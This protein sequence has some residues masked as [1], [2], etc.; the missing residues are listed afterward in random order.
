MK[1]PHCTATENVLARLREAADQ[2]I[3]K[4][5]VRL[6]VPEGNA[7]GVS[8]PEI[9]RIARTIGK[10][11]GLAEALWNTGWREARILA[12]LI[13]PR[14]AATGPLL[15]RW[16]SECDSWAEVD[17]LC[18]NLACRSPHSWQLVEPWCSAQGELQ[19]RAGFVLIACLALHDKATPDKAFEELLV[20]IG[21]GAN[22]QRN[23]VMK[24]VSWAL[25]EIGKRSP[26]LC[27]KALETAGVLACSESTAARWI[28]RDALRDLEKKRFAPKQAGS[29]A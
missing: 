15:S 7:L 23:L 13:M 29:G 10:D 21:Q 16:A 22:D 4:S 11:A 9:R 20:L 25:R 18:A 5:Y 6:G 26:A 28:G 3:V 17:A 27:P 1:R 12:T 8:V 2:R 24:A 19:R 14:D